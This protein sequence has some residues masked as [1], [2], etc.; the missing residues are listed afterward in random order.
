MILVH[1][2]VISM[3]ATGV[4]S[5]CERSPPIDSI[6]QQLAAIAGCVEYGSLLDSFVENGTYIDRRDKPLSACSQDLLW[7][8]CVI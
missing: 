3:L 1:G 4:H 8:T 2:G 5:M 7:R 6:M